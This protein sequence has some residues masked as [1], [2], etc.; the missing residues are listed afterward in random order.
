MGKDDG[1]HIIISFNGKR[2]NIWCSSG[3]NGK[4]EGVKRPSECTMSRRKVMP[5]PFPVLF[6]AKTPWIIVVWKEIK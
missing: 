4:Y 5:K 2:Y 3:L 6:E 1:L